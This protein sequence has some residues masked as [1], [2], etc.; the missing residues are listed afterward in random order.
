MKTY[1]AIGSILTIAI[2][3]IVAKHLEED[4]FQEIYKEGET[5]TLFMAIWIMLGIFIIFWPIVLLKIIYRVY[6]DR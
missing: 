2:S 6:K 1:L 4:E 5:S 3:L